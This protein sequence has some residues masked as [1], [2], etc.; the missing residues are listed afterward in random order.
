MGKKHPGTAMVT[1]RLSSLLSAALPEV[2]PQPAFVACPVVLIATCCAGQQSWMH[3]IY[4]IALERA[5]SLHRPS[6]WAPLYRAWA[7]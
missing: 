3:E 5:Q 1:H 7:N 2:A 6:R 4:R